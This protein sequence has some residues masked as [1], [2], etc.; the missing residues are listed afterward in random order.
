MAE[1]RFL[2]IAFLAL[3]LVFIWY[4]LFFQKKTFDSKSF[5]ISWRKILLQKIQFYQNLD[6]AD[7][8]RFELG[9]L[10]FLDR[11]DI[12]GIELDV[13]DEDKL[14]VASSAVIPLFGFPGWEYYNL[15]EVLLYKGTF[16][17][18]YQTQ[19][20]KRNILGMVGEGAMNRMM[21][22]SLPALQQGFE[23]QHTKSNVGIHEF[24]HLLDK[25]D[26]DTDGI[27]QTMISRQF[28]IPWMKKVHEEIQ[29]IKDGDSDINPYGATNEAEF[30]SVVSEYF[31]TK[32]ERLKHEHPELFNMLETIYKQD[33]A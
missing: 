6:I 12:T 15:N 1:T 18:D 8:P 21:I 29:D 22:L 26:S 5:P 20:K 33:L 11:V 17:H 14:L 19:G 27:P 10:H 23:N 25:F 7:R 2:F 30:L 3:A 24:V 32:P 9:I 16:N 13:T 28:V 31:F 4:K